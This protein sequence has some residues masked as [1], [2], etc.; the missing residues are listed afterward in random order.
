MADRRKAFHEQVAE[1]LIEQLRQG[2]APW[3]KPWQPGEPGANIPINPVTGRRYRGI[4]I[5]QLMMQD[6]TD[7]RW[8]TYKQAESAGAQVLKGEKGTSIQYWKFAEEQTITDEAGRPVLD[9]QG[10]PRKGQLTLERP[11]V[12]FAT[13]FNAE[14]IEGL[15]PLEH[16]EPSWQILDR[17]EN[18]LQ[19]SSAVI[20]HGQHDRAFYRASTDSIH[21]PGR[22]QFKTAD[23]YYATALHELGHWTGHSSR[24]NRDL[25]NPYGSVE[26]SKEE[27]R[28]EIASM[29][30]GDELGI[31]H[32][33]GQHAAYVG[34]WIQVL[35]ENP[36][37]IFRASAD[38]ERIRDYILSFEQQQEL[39]INQI[40][41]QIEEKMPGQLQAQPY[42]VSMSQPVQP[43]NT[44][45]KELARLLALSNVTPGNYTPTDN[46]RNANH[47][48]VF[49]N[50][51][52]VILCGSADDQASVAMV[53]A[54][55][56][57][58]HLQVACQAAGISGPI[59]TGVIVGRNIQWNRTE[60]AVVSKPSGMIEPGGEDG[61]VVAVVLN[62]P[63]QALVTS[64]CVTTE[65][66][67]IFDPEAPELDD[68][69]TLAVLAAKAVD[70]VY[71]QVPFKEKDEA[72]VLG[73]RWDRRERSWFIPAQMDS[74]PFEKW[75][76]KQPSLDQE[77]GQTNQKQAYRFELHDPRS[78][79]TY[80]FTNAADVIAKA[81]EIEGHRFLLVYAD[82]KYEHIDKVDG[83]WK[84]RDGKSFTVEDENLKIIQSAPIP[85][86][87]Y[88]AVPYGERSAA[89]ASGA[90]WDKTA[91]SW[92]VGPDADMKKL[93]RWMPQI[94]SG[95]DPAMNPKEEFTD[96][97]EAL[98]CIVTGEHPI[99][100]GQKHRIG[101]EG[102]RKGDQAGYYICHLDGHP[103]GYIKNYRTG[104]DMKWKAKGYSLDSETK[105][106][107][108]AVAAAK[109]AKRADKLEELHEAT[110]Q[111]IIL[112]MENLVPVAEA[113]PYMKNKGIQP[114]ASAFTDGDYKTTYIP[115]YDAYGKLWNMQ[116]IQESGKKRFAKNS[117]KEGCFH[118]V[119]G[120]GALATAPVLVIAE[121]YATAATLAEVLG[122][123]TVSAFDSG[124][125]LP[126]ARAL[127]QKYPGKPI[128]IAGDDDLNV[129]ATLGINPGRV[130]ATEAAR[131]VGGKAIFPIFA[132]GEQS[133]ESKAFTD[134]NDLAKSSILGMDGVKR[135]IQPVIDTVMEE[136][137][138]QAESKQEFKTVNT[139][140]RISL[141]ER[142]IRKSSYRRTV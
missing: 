7:Q 97:L 128:I 133:A 55:A 91:K 37:E 109:Q 49:V 79:A 74:T 98:G 134:F 127:H 137:E 114:H 16:K 132:P 17:T 96:A 30:L 63:A 139:K 83:V 68:G 95:Q 64:L 66:A 81:G 92:Y 3:Q 58:G 22:D 20:L 2:T 102:D 32:D 31:G 110:A 53:E 48:A 28:A 117:K 65:T 24:L 44:Y 40:H 23:Q 69:R 8:L 99:M 136:L 131:A 60:S 103:A 6:R 47:T 108:Q 38:A 29:I 138:Q 77:I 1:K 56:A 73:A 104:I 124:N 70:R 19:A 85:E 87:Q 26:Y 126:V 59:K 41:S 39:E 78:D 21:L 9:D 5:I 100:D 50:D 140:A 11:R 86:R 111:R 90:L 33:P 51:E 72:K 101:V 120:M 76:N 89:K 43:E 82:G 106:I 35:E 112:Q 93:E 116:Y 54:L 10:Q 115:A 75:L 67:R 4:N 13:V 119:G 105:V 122:Q 62:D 46:F 14:Q 130:K 12:F 141:K 129:G 107:L 113:T 15:P 45:Q 25:L 135:Q 142:T 27:L 42:E 94:S 71:L 61:P 125:L 84:Y 18:I 88:L 52:P 57:S 118:P 36:L 121:G 34:S 80:R 123:A